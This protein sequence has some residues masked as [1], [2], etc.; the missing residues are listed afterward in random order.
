MTSCCHCGRTLY[1]GPSVR[2]HSG[3]WCYYNKGPCGFDYNCAYDEPEQKPEEFKKKL[4]KGIAKG[5]VIGAAIG[6]TCLIA[7][8]ACIITAFIHHHYYLKSAASSV[9]SVMKNRSEHAQ[10][11][12]KEAAVSGTLETSKT[13]GTE[14]LSS[15]LGAKFAEIAH[16]MSG[17]SLSWAGEI[18]K[19]TARGMLEQGS[20]A[21]FDW[22]SKTLV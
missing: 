7:H 9:Y 16:E 22:G 14:V 10:H 21:V 18:G 11:P 2:R 5:A 13:A 19:E 1:Y 20:S 6:V 3:S 8:V 4:I 12:V 15:K 17:A